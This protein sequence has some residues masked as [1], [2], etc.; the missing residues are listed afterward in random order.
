MSSVEV[1]NKVQA[2]QWAILLSSQEVMYTAVEGTVKIVPGRHYFQS[3]MTIYSWKLIFS[4]P[5]D[6]VVAQEHTNKFA[7][8]VK[9]PL[10]N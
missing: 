10:C 3:I 4:R 9:T 8:F 6:T 1:P 5:L 7:I 2:L